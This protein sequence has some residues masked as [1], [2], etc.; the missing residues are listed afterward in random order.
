MQEMKM[1][2]QLWLKCRKRTIQQLHNIVCKEKFTWKLEFDKKCQADI[3]LNFPHASWKQKVAIV[4]YILPIFVMLK[5]LC[6]VSDDDI[7]KLQ[8]LIDTDTNQTTILQDT[9]CRLETKT[10][11]YKVPR[12]FA[13]HA[14]CT[15]FAKQLQKCPSLR[16]TDD[17]LNDLKLLGSPMQCNETSAHCLVTRSILYYCEYG[18]PEL[19]TDHDINHSASS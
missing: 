15:N 12:K 6:K 7:Q 18:T 19:C 5:R 13:E 16:L 4:S 11:N 17:E 10:A 1:A 14:K 9:L 3:I 2:L 8:S